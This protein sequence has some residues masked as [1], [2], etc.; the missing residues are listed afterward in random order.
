MTGASTLFAALLASLAPPRSPSRLDFTV[1]ATY[2]HDCSSFTQGLHFEPETGMLLESTGLYGES[3]VRRVDIESGRAV[4]E[5]PLDRQWFGEGLA[6]VGDLCY[7]LLWR[8]NICLI[9][10]YVT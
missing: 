5:T 10:T 1:L 3:S 2:P 7:Q 6:V 9:H 4:R 8:E